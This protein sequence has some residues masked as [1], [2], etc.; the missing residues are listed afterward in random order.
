MIDFQSESRKNVTKEQSSRDHP[1]M[2]A[3]LRHVFLLSD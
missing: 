2:I 1:G 3:L